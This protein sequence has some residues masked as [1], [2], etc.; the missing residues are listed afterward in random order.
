MKSVRVSIVC[1]YVIGIGDVPVPSAP[2]STGKSPAFNS[3]RVYERVFW[4]SF[5]GRFC[6]SESARARAT[7]HGAAVVT[8][9]STGAWSDG[10]SPLRCARSTLLAVQ[11]CA[12]VDV[13]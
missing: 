8:S 12:T 3:P 7:G 6:L 1:A 11:R 2:H 10:C 13:P 5:I 9:H 4:G